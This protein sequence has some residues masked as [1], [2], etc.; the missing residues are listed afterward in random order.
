LQ[1]KRNEEEE[2]RGAK[3]ERKEKRKCAAVHVGEDRKSK[4]RRIEDGLIEEK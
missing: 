1:K 2:G 3:G 4:E